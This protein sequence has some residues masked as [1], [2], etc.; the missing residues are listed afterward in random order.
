MP[1]S[2]Q[3]TALGVRVHVHADHTPAGGQELQGAQRPVAD[4]V[5]VHLT[6]VGILDTSERVPVESGTPDL[7]DRAMSRIEP[8]TG[9]TPGLHLTDGREHRHG[10]VTPGR[11]QRDCSE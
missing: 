3:G 7:R 9:E 6:L 5:S 2:H 11:R 1:A 4:L 8:V 10:E